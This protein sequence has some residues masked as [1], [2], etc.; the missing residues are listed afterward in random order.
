MPVY[1]GEGDQQDR[2]FHFLQKSVS[3]IMTNSTK[4]FKPQQIL[5]VFPKL[6]LTLVFHIM[7]EKKHPSI[8]I[9]RVLTHIHSMFLYCL[10]RFPEL[11]DSIR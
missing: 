4:N 2:F 7:D 3:M 11:K 1:F 10:K 8:R 5:E 9:I 6:F